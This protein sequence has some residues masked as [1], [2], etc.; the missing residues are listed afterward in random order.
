MKTI[1]DKLFYNIIMRDEEPNVS[2]EAINGYIN[3]I[4]DTKRKNYDVTYKFIKCFFPLKNMNV[5][6]ETTHV[7]IGNNGQFTFTLDAIDY[8]TAMQW[9]DTIISCILDHK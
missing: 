1:K 4:I 2:I 6:Y 9:Y 5:K 7:H 3:I 8:S